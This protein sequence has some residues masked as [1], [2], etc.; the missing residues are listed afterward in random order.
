[1]TPDVLPTMRRVAGNLVPD[2][3]LVRDALGMRGVP[4]C[5]TLYKDMARAGIPLVDA[6]D[7]HA[8]FHSLRY[9]F[10]RLMGEVLPIQIVKVLMRHATIA[11]TADLYGKL[12]IDDLGEKVWSLPS[13]GIAEDEKT[14]LVPPVVPEPKQPDR[15][16]PKPLPAK[17]TRQDSNL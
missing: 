12:G 4:G 5:R 14:V 8:D 3:S 10:C 2:G 6:Y 15:T 11:L 9:T 17:Y 7:R 16:R 13:L 1:M